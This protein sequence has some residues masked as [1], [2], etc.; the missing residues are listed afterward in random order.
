MDG[1]TLRDRLRYQFDN[2][3]ARGIVGQMAMLALLSG[4]LV[5][6]GALVLLLCGLVPA[7]DDGG[8]VSFPML[9]WMT[10]M[11]S[12]DAGT[13]GGDEGS[14]PYLLV[15]LGVTLGGIFVLSTLIGVLN[16]AIEGTLDELRKGR[17]KVVERGHTILLGWSPKTLMML[18]ELAMANANK[19]GACVVVLSER[20]KVEMDDAIRAH[21]GRTKLRVV[22]RSGSPS[23][24]VDLEIASPG[25]ARV[26]VVSS[27]ED[28]GL[29]PNEADTQV[30]K[31]LLAVSKLEAFTSGRLHVVAELREERA[32]DVARM[33][34][35]QQ[36]ALVVSPSLISRLLV[37]TGR[38]SGL[39]VV[40][41]ELLGF[42]GHELYVVPPASTV[43]LSFI[44]AMCRFDDSVLVGVFDATDRLWLPPPMDRVIAAT[45]RLIAISQDDDTVR[46]NGKDGGPRTAPRTPPPPRTSHP[47]RT[48]VLGASERLPTVL[49]ELDAYVA[50]GSEVIVLGE[51]LDASVQAE[52]DR[53]AFAHITVSSHH[54]DVTDRRLLDA[55]DIGGFDHVL[56]LAETEGRTQDMAD[57]RTMVTLLHLRDIAHRSGKVVPVTTEMLDL[58]NQELA[59]VAEADDFIVSNTLVATIMAQVAENP[60]LVRVFD[61]LF[62]PSGSEIYLKP[63]EQ[64]APLD[65]DLDFY[66][67]VRDAAAQGAV[68]IGYRIAADAKNPRATYGVTVNPRKQDRLTLRA[69]DKVIVIADS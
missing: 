56:V 1:V 64:Y 19:P 39:S 49:R 40:Y 37:Q 6:G 42:A 55:L 24:P 66:T 27:P 4:G 23:S 60:Y 3:M 34:V 25:S 18:H 43:G 36:A 69:G 7:G 12:M 16:S 15:M 21:L 14:W 8:A 38:Q 54:G 52:L 17:S 46:P 51:P 44:D 33:I 65:T 57:A 50:P 47:E 48:L 63:A 30:I 41:S 45:D 35:G 9:V 62:D 28:D 11:R 58:R 5:V 10:L 26:V 67:I 20:D 59:S 13:V 29:A 53:A 2:L 32:R 31:A 22:T 61:D 68:A